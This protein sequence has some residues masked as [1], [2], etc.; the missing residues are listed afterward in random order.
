MWVIV[1]LRCQVLCFLLALFGFYQLVNEPDSFRNILLII[2]HI[3][4]Q[5][6]VVPVRVQQRHPLKYCI[7][8]KGNLFGPLWFVPHG[9]S[10]Y[11]S[12]DK[13]VPQYN[14]ANV[15]ISFF[16]YSF[17]TLNQNSKIYLSQILI[18]SQWPRHTNR[19]NPEP[20]YC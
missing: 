9:Y 17:T 20:S 10:S 1:Q 4:K 14:D 8:V 15:L 19:L 2:L 13:F 16:Y 7:P 11:S 5:C 6:H 3:L 18:T 12:S